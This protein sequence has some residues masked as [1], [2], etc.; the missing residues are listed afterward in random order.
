MAS[1]SSSTVLVSPE[2]GE[3]AA[4]TAAEV[5]RLLARGYTRKADKKASA[6][7]DKK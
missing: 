1:K 4:T 7:E 3:Y 5:T 6:A 2:G